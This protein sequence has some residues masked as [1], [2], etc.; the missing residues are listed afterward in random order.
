MDAAVAAA[1]MKKVK[2]GRSHR[3]YQASVRQGRKKEGGKKRN[4]M[5]GEKVREQR[6]DT[7]E[8]HG[9]NKIGKG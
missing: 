7:G 6:Q 9:K 1:S 3:E 2:T 8:T 4:R 5:E